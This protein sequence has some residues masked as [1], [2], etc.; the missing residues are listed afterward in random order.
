MSGKSHS[1]DFVRFDIKKIEHTFT[2]T[3]ECD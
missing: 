3:S 1:F 2:S